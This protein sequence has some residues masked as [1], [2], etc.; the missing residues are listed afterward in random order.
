MFQKIRTFQLDHA[1]C[2]LKRYLL[3]SSYCFSFMLREVCAT[4]PTSG[5][6]SFGSEFLRNVWYVVDYFAGGRTR[7]AAS[8]CT[9]SLLY[10]RHQRC[11]PLPTTRKKRPVRLR[12]RTSV[13]F[14][15]AVAYEYPIIV[16]QT[17]TTLL[18][19]SDKA[20]PAHAIK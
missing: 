17:A 10:L 5:F 9:I 15:F 3:R 20:P 19:W 8:S 12:S 18:I 6:F 7:V 1:R 13:V 2:K 4:K 11:K 14:S 16:V